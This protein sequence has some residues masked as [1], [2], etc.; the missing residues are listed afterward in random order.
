MRKAHPLTMGQLFL[1]KGGKGPLFFPTSR[2][3]PRSLVAQ[4]TEGLNV[5]ACVQ[6]EPRV[7]REVGQSSGGKTRKSRSNK[8]WRA[9]WSADF[10][11]AEPQHDE[12]GNV[13]CVNCAICAEIKKRP[14]LIKNKR[15]NLMKHSGNRR[16]KSRFQLGN[17]VVEVGQIYSTPDCEHAKNDAKWIA[18]GL[19][20]RNPAVVRVPVVTREMSKKHLQFVLVFDLLL[21]GRPMTDYPL[22]EQ[23][24]DFL[25]VELPHQHWSID[26]G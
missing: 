4:A 21:K 3:L 12:N 13:S 23:L 2:S 19:A 6:V 22:F 5:E 16:A 8:G 14:V 20:A 7:Q 17:C 25:R 10:P 1:L 24:L 18:R 11:W 9:E 26:S 15:D